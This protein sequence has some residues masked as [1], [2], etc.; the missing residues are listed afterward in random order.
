MSVKRQFFVGEDQCYEEFLL[1][2]CPIYE[3][4]YIGSLDCMKCSRF[5]RLH[6]KYD[7]DGDFTDYVICSK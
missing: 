5:R 6:E 7:K 2:K 1:T 4:I 3:N